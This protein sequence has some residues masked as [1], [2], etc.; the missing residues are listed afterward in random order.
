[1]TY[2]DMFGTTIKVGDFIVYSASV[3]ANPGIKVGRVKKL[4]TQVCKFG[5][6]VP[7]NVPALDVKCAEYSMYSSKWY[8][9]SNAWKVSKAQLIRFNKILVVD[10]KKIPKNVRDAL[11]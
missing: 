1:M 4:T 8:D 6:P 2:K 7:V 9:E 10:S 3:F 5:Q 11:K